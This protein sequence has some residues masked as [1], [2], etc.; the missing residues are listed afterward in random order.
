MGSADAET[1]TP[2]NA[3][4][5]GPGALRWAVK[6]L[7]SLAVVAAIL[8]GTAGRLDWPMGW[9]FVV[10]T[11]LNY[12]AT[13]V[14][15]SRSDPGLVAERSRI[16]KGTKR[17]D[18]V[19]APLVA[20]GVVF[21]LVAAALDLRFGWT[22]PT[23]AWIQVA[24]LLATASG[25]A[26]GLW[27]L[28]SNPFFSAM[29]RIQSERGH[30]AVTGGPYRFVRHPG[31]AGVAAYYLALPVMMGSLWAYLPAAFSLGVLAV[32]TVL[33]DR[34]LQRELDGYRDY[35]R[36]VRFRIIPGIW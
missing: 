8:F 19:L 27:A 9:A 23:P 11:A 22:G 6:G 24:A 7:V 35:A 3:A 12:A 17:W 15:L 13:A 5:A 16:H 20:Y 2:N 28:A 29:V 18:Y 26:L 4:S 21:I 31:Y 33:E 30:V 36:R 32:R 25:S 34:T 10:L 1:N 14:I